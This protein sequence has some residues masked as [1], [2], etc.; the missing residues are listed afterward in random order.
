MPTVSH[1]IRT[2]I[3]TNPILILLGLLPN[4][5]RRLKYDFSWIS[6]TS[7]VCLLPTNRL[8]GLKKREEES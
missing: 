3:W 5:T 2:Q 8:L 7:R 4:L 6:R 1:N